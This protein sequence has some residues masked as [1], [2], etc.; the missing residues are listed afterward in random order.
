MTRKGKRYLDLLKRIDHTQL[1]SPSEAVD[2]ACTSEARGV[3]DE[4]P[5]RLSHRM[6]FGASRTLPDGPT[7]SGA[8]EVVPRAK[9]MPR[10]KSD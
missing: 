7:S 1:Y 2:G 8:A 9:E 3:T 4:K 5:A 10:E 6:A